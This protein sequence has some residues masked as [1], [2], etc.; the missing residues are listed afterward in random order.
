[1]SHP[2]SRI[3][4]ARISRIVTLLSLIRKHN[5]NLESEYQQLDQE[6]AN[7]PFLHQCESYERHILRLK[8]QPLEAQEDLVQLEELLASRLLHHRRLHTHTDSETL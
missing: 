4:F 6:C 3:Q 8:S 7:F 1:M 5:L 2:S